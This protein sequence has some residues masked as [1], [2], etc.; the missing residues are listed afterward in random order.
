M[1]GACV[2]ALLGRHAGRS[3]S[4]FRLRRVAAMLARAILP[5]AGARAPASDRVPCTAIFAQQG[6]L[7]ILAARGA[8]PAPASPAGVRRLEGARRL[9]RADEAL[10]SSA[11]DDARAEALAELERAPRD[12]EALRRLVEIDERVPGRAEAA[13]AAIAEL[14]GDLA[15]RLGP[16]PGDLRAQSGDIAGAI[17]AYERA[18]EDEPCGPLASRAYERGAALT[19][20]PALASSL[21]DRAIAR[22]PRS[23]SARW[24]R[25]DAR[26]A[27]G[28]LDDALADAEHLEAL[29]RTAD[30]KHAVWMRAGAAFR[31]A[32]LGARS[33]AIFERALR[34]TPDDPAALAGL[35]AALAADPAGAAA[36]S[37]RPLDPSRRA[38][39]GVAL[40]SRAADRA[41]ATGTA[42][43]AIEL[44]LARALADVLRDLPAAIA[45]AGLVP[46]EAPEFLPARTL[47]G[48][49]RARLGD[50]AGASLAFAQL[51]ERA[52]TLT[53]DP[54]ITGARGGAADAVIDGLFEAARFERDTRGDLL[55]A[56]RHLAV[57]LR[58]RPQHEEAG[59]D[60]RALGAALVGVTLPDEPPSE[61]PPSEQQVP[62]A[63]ASSA[64]GVS[65]L[66]M[67]D[68][69][70]P[71]EA[72][73][74]A[75]EL[76]RRLHADPTNDAVAGE[77]A[78][79]LEDLGRHHELLA[80]LSARL[81]D[82][83]PERRPALLPRFRETLE[84]LARGAE[85]AGRADEAALY[86]SVL[87]ATAS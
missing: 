34:F 14:A 4:I 9:G 62:A 28:R 7:S 42:A 51:R 54:E 17:A 24:A 82:A 84:R 3:G 72:S 49:W 70:A 85:G 33:G 52:A 65:A 71:A 21:L 69:D 67:F 45:H 6:T 68:D 8:T 47:E 60:Y 30:A 19:K 25:L 1:A 27:L 61:P 74:K 38:A 15:E 48:R 5:E 55:A 53:F 78:A 59:R 41:Y 13:L 2:A 39:R 87:A 10:R 23:C 46:P 76:T 80:L 57:A 50:L 75:E 83:P 66:A 31:R 56:Q 20:D 22:A 18:A 29:V 35:G 11:D 37:S 16:T 44:D 73:A 81:E 79:V 86:R 32:G 12:S 64:S 63:I 26:L 36:A 77:L 40:L 43:A 58:I